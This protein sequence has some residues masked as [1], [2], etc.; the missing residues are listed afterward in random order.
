[1][2]PHNLKVG[3]ELYMVPSRRMGDPRMVTIAKIGRIWA[4]LEGHTGR[5]CMERLFLDGGQY[6]SRASCY[7]SKDDYLQRKER[8]RVWNEFSR[9]VDQ[10]G[11]HED[12]SIAGIKRAAFILGIGIKEK[13]DDTA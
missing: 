10:M 13:S 9:Q 6:S 4:T 7:L 1:M 12:I 8:E 3:Q 2:N 11:L 5:I